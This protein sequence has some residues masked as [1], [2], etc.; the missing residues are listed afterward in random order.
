MTLTSGLSSFAP[1]SGRI[2]QRPMAFKPQWWW[3]HHG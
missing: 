2:A 3:E 1:R